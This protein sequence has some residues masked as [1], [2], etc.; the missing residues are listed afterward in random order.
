MIRHLAGAL[1]L[2]APPALAAPA[3]APLALAADT[4]ILAI[5]FGPDRMQVA[6]PEI[7]TV[8]VRNDYGVPYVLVTLDP[9]L[10]FALASL[11]LVHVGQVGRILVCDRVVSEPLLQSA[12]TE[13]VFMIANGDAAEVRRLAAILRARSCTPEATS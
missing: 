1:V 11:T 10:Q 9:S 13:A 5:E 6:P 3:L 2:L 4:S 12:I 8:E 7:L